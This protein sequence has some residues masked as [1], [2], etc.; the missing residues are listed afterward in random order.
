MRVVG[1]EVQRPDGSIV[2]RNVRPWP[3]ERLLIAELVPP[4]RPSS[5]SGAGVTGLLE[6]VRRA[7]S[8]PRLLMSDEELAEHQNDP[9]AC[10]RC[11]GGPMGIGPDGEQ[12]CVDCAAGGLLDAL[13]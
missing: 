6:S 5:I 11:G 4:F 12:V 2:A 1:T 10:A 7:L 13:C 9:N 8:D 3:G